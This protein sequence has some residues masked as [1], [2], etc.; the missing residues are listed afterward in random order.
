MAITCPV[1]LAAMKL[2]LRVDSADDNTMISQLMA[3]ATE[4]LENFQQRTFITKERILQLDSFPL[5][6][7]PPYPP[8]LT[9]ESIEYIDTAGDEQTLDEAYYRVDTYNE[10]GRVTEAY[11]YCWP[12]TQNV[13]GAVTIT[14]TAGY[15]AAADVPDDIKT[16]IMNIVQFLYERQGNLELLKS[17][18]EIS[19]MRRIMNL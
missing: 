2:F 1:E 9:I 5:I 4:W 15:G 16:E 14:Y 7:Q 11:N 6:I 10:P 8:L 19:W 13:T 17:A 3:A 18:K 12:S